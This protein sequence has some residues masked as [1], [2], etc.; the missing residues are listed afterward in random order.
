[1]VDGWRTTAVRPT[2][3]QTEPRELQIRENAVRFHGFQQVAVHGEWLKTS[4]V[5][6]SLCQIEP[7][8]LQI[9]ENERRFH[10]FQQV[11]VPGE[12]LEDYRRQTN[13]ESD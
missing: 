11:V 2:L 1:M 13:P 3:C 8:E 9:R 4:A 6:P 12:G 7:G 5:R 10:G